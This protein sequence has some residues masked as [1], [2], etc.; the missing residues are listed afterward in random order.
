M[1]IEARM[2]AYNVIWTT[3]S[4]GASKSM[5]CG[6]GDIGLNVLVESGDVL[7]YLARSGSLD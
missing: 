1:N 6:G 3:P 7:Y 5:P 4:R 2:D